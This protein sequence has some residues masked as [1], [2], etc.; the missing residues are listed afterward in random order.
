MAEIIILTDV[1]GAWGFG[2]YAGAYKVATELR[3][4]GF[5]VQVV[6]FF[7]DLETPQVETMLDK[8]VDERTLIVGFATTLMI[9]RTS[10]GKSAPRSARSERNRVARTQ[11]LPQ[12]DEW[13]RDF[14]DSI[15]RRNPNVKLVV[16]G[17]KANQMTLDGIDFWIVGEADESI[18]AL[19]Q[20]LKHG[21]PLKSQ[22]GPGGS[23]VISTLQ[24]PYNTFNRSQIKW[25]PEDHIFPGEHLPIEIARGCIFKCAFCAYQL[26]GKKPG[27]FVKPSSLVRDEMLYNH[28]NFGTTGYMFCDDTYNDSPDKVAEY[29]RM[30]TSLPFKIEFSTFARLDL[31]WRYS[32]QREQLFESGLRSIFFGIETLNPVAGKRIGKGAD[33][34]KIKE[35][36]HYLKELWADEVVVSAGFIVGLPGEPEE[37]VWKTVDWLMSDDCPLDGFSFAALNIREATPSADPSISVSK[38]ALAPEKYGYSGSGDGW[39]NEYMSRERAKQIVSEIDRMTLAKGSI[40]EFAFAS[41]LRNLGY[42]HHDCLHRCPNDQSFV[43]DIDRRHGELREKYLQSLLS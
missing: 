21:T 22:P 31:I 32:E 40:G 17:G 19:A 33:P 27:D 30:I 29:H 37:S 43:G 16:G 14:I 11:L 12:D 35:T 24:Y 28:A 15:R 42:S 39:S 5:S 3:E 20:A 26:N 6:E 25:V 4:R 36:L 13:V 23:R 9:A 10:G 34:E 8:F 1:N 41:R 18:V 7:A 38:M 2:R